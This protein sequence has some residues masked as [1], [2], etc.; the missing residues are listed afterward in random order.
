MHIPVLKN[1][2]ISYLNVVEGGVY[3]DCTFGAGGYSKEILKTKNTIVYAI[4]RDPNAEKFAQ[5]IKENFS[6]RFYL[7]RGNFSNACALLEECKINSV[8]GIVLDAGVSSM[9][10]DNA[11]RGFS[12]QTEAPLD[13]RM[14]MDGTSAYDIVNSMEERQ[15]ADLIYQYGDES[16]S[17]KIARNI[18]FFRKTK[19]IETT[20]ELAQIIR[21]SFP[22]KRGKIDHATKTFQ[23]IR[24]AV[25]N[26]LEELKNLLQS[27][28]RLLNLGSRLVVVSFHS[29]EDRIVKRFMEN[30]TGKTKGV[31]R[32]SVSVINEEIPQ[33]KIIA[34]RAIA[35]S[36]EE[37]LVNPRARSAKLRCMERIGGGHD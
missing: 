21:K 15:L 32:H 37:I 11:E 4:D 22:Y 36:D 28:D 16:N 3:L 19:K 26:E 14:S 1:E 24:I 13:M 34:K 30:A 2:A 35:P 10:L 7:L 23:A 20:L 12:F 29:L 8:D 18:S 9:Q 31:S 27:S 6:N 17:R 25:N 33:Y 5:E